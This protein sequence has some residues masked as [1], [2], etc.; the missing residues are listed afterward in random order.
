MTTPK[1]LQIGT[2]VGSLRKGSLNDALAR[3]LP[4]YAPADMSIR[5]LPS[6]G[7]IPHYNADVQ[8]GSWPAAVTQLG[9]AIRGLDGVIVVTPEYNYSIPGVLKNAIDWLSRLPNQPFANKAVAIQSASMGVLGGARAQYHLRQVFVFLDASVF[10][11]PEVMVAQAQNKLSVDAGDITDQGTRDVVTAQLKAFA[12][13]VRKQGA[14]GDR[15]LDEILERLLGRRACVLADD[16]AVLEDQQGRDA[17]DLILARRR[18]IVVN[19]HLGDGDLPAHLFRQRLERGRDLLAG[20]AP[21]GPE[22][23]QHG[24]LGLE[25]EHLEIGIGNGNRHVWPPGGHPRG[26]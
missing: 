10:N 19:V 13:F 5:A 1:Q 6:V 14:R 7:E 22:V 11:R 9:D 23:D 3:A 21:L 2:L 17:A 20:P 24:A 16:F 26:K 18:R 25:D 15:A 4:K 12:A 8:A